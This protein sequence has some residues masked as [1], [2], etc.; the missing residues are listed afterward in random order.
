MSAGRIFGGL[1]ALFGGVFVMIAVFLNTSEVTSGTDALVIRW[2]IN[3]IICLFA[4]I[5]GIL[6][7]A[8]KG[9]GG[10]L[11]LIAGILA[12]L[13]VSLQAF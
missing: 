10:A 12:F 5:G 8:A 6:A 4:I 13:R 3:L 9:G 7:I 2:I 1:F 11:A